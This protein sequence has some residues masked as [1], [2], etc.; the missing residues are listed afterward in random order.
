M[1]ESA[2][3]EMPGEEAGVELASGRTLIQLAHVL[4]RLEDRLLTRELSLSYRQMRILKHVNAGV[5]SATE[6]GRIFGV[7]APAISETLESLVKKKLLVRKAH[8]TDRRVVKLALTKKG[9]QL[10]A[11]AEEAERTLAAEVLAPLSSKEIRT[12]Q[13]LVTK[14]IGPNQEN[15]INSRLASR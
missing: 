6:M 14:L 8:E 11:R 2:A 3:K 9:E 7:T 1:S 4:V 5:T 13:K 15:L 10:N 12:L